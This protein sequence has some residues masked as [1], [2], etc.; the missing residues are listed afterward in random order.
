VLVQLENN[1]NSIDSFVLLM[2]EKWLLASE[3]KRKNPRAP[4]IKS[5]CDFHAEGCML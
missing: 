5:C 1:I 4:F 2:D 3:K